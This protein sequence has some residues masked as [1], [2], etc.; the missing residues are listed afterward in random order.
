MRR[1]SD[2]WGGTCRVVF[3]IVERGAFTGVLRDELRETRGDAAV[4]A[5]VVVTELWIGPRGIDGCSEGVKGGLRCR[6]HWSVRMRPG[7]R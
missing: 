7:V 2:V 4:D 1:L 5:S 3:Q 6:H